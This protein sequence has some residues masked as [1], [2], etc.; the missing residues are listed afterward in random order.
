[1]TKP[2]KPPPYTYVR[3]YYDVPAY[4]GMAVRVRGRSGVLVKPRRDDQY[5]YI[6]FDGETRT[7]G[8]FHPTDEIEYLPIGS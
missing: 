7:A 8:P 3:S 2:Q 1:M 6:R 5:V 4:V